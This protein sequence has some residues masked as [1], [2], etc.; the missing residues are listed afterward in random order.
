MLLPCCCRSASQLLPAAAQGADQKL[1]SQTQHQLHQHQQH[2]LLLQGVES[3]Q[4]LHGKILQL[5]LLLWSLKDHL[6]LLLLLLGPK[7]AA[8]HVA[9]LAVQTSFPVQ[10]RE[11]SDYQPSMRQQLPALRLLLLLLRREHRWRGLLLLPLV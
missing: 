7:A 5:L 2:L 1:A 11:P 4:Q 3:V 9:S 6:L 10:Q 8:L